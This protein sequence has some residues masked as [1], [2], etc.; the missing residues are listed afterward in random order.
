MFASG[1]GLVAGLKRLALATKEARHLQPHSKP[2]WVG[3]GLWLTWD[4]SR[5]HLL[6]V[7]CGSRH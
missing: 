2:G 6:K 4:F 3:C 7:E 5:L 1:I